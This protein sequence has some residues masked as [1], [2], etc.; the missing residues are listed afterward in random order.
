MTESQERIAKASIY[1]PVPLGGAAHANHCI[2]LDSA[3]ERIRCCA[4]DPASANITPVQ[5]HVSDL[6]RRSTNA[7]DQPRDRDAAHNIVSTKATCVGAAPID[8]TVVA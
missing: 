1:S 5:K 2:S 7:R 3:Q 4:T 8:I 6:Y